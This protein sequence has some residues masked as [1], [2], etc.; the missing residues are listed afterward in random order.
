M[1]QS[2]TENSPYESPVEERLLQEGPHE[3]RGKGL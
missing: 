2:H 3:K 1:A